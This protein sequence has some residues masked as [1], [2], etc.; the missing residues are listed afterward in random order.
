MVVVVRVAVV[1][2]VLGLRLG[3]A[4]AWVD[5]NWVVVQTM[6]EEDKKT[7]KHFLLLGLLVVMQARSMG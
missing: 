4:V 2:D 3:G 7:I 1:G 5:F 6:T